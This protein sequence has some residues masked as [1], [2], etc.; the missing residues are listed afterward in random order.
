MAEIDFQPA[1]ISGIELQGSELVIAFPG[2]PLYDERTHARGFV[3]FYRCELGLAD[4]RL[5]SEDSPSLAL[6]VDN[7]WVEYRNKG[8]G[9]HLPLGFHEDGPVEV[10]IGFA[11]EQS[12]AFEWRP[13]VAGS[14]ITLRVFEKVE[15]V[16]F[17]QMASDVWPSAHDEEKS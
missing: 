16:P 11:I 1:E 8:R 3:S 12:G 2:Q 9:F 13:L 7:L 5:L 15:D 14:N 4:G 6:H 10:R 17:V